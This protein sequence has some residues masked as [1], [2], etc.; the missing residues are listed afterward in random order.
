MKKKKS[1]AKKKINHRE[2][3]RWR[4]LPSHGREPGSISP[5][6]FA[7]RKALAEKKNLKI[8]V[9]PPNGFSYI[10]QYAPFRLVSLERN[11]TIILVKNF[12]REKR[13]TDN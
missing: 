12:S 5:F 1:Q 9:D 6:L 3:L 11:E 8:R 13:F 7:K 2:K 10:S 4:T